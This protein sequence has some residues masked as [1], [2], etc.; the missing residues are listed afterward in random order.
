[1]ADDPLTPE[2]SHLTEQV[3]VATA[4]RKHLIA[5]F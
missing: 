5:A 3:H 2:A 1:M 4:D